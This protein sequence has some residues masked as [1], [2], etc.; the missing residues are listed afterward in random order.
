MCIHWNK[1]VAKRVTYQ[2][3]GNGVDRWIHGNAQCRA[4][5]G[6]DQQQV[7]YGCLDQ[8]VR[9][10]ACRCDDD[11][12]EYLFQ[13]GAVVHYYF[14]GTD[15]KKSI[16]DALLPHGNVSLSHYDAVFANDGNWPKM[17]VDDVCEAAFELQALSVPFLWLSTY[18][19]HG[20]VD[21]W[22]DAQKEKFSQSGARFVNVGHMLFGLSNFTKG[23]VEDR[24]DPH[25][26]LPGPPDELGFLLLKIIWALYQERGAAA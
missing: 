1:V 2:Q 4:C 7:D 23:A 22:N 26:C 16:K 20:S 25:F 3:P 5:T 24:V 21:L 13:N 15:P 6:F 10:D 8:D 12:A 17:A 19:G 18:D 14:A 11:H 9:D